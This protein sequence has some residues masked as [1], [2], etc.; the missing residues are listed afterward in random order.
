M[1]RRHEAP[2]ELR[3]LDVLVL[4]HRQR[5]RPHHARRPRDDRNGDG[6]HHVLHGRAQDRGDGERQ[7]QQREG[8]QDVHHPLEE[9]VDLAAA[10]RADD[11]QEGAERAPR[12][13]GDEAHEERDARP[14]HDPAQHVAA[15]LVGPEPVLRARTHELRAVVAHVGVVGR[16]RVREEGDEQHGQDDQRARD[17]RAASSG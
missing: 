14:V 12:E 16:E 8:E 17:A 2:S 15:E 10:V 13:R 4:L 11:A 6:H 3:G 5:G 7:D 9:K 1:T